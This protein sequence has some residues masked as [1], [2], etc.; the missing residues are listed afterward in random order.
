MHVD[1]ITGDE[2]FLF[3]TSCSTCY[4]KKASILPLMAGKESG[5]TK[6][7]LHVEE[8]ADLDSKIYR[9]PSATVEVPELGM[10]VEPSGAGE[11]FV[12]NVEGMLS[13][14]K[15][16]LEF[17]LKTRQAELSTVKRARETLD[18]IESC[19]TGKKSFHVILEDPEGFSY[20][21]PTRKSSL[22]KTSITTGE[23]T[24]IS[25]DEKNS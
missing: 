22:E 1:K 2:T 14:F 15:E 18:E 24:G 3:T 23:T 7:I 21:L 9:A 16:R 12:T 20:I 4:F 10:K 8:L 19:S 11:I 6:S 17:I 13:R 25:R 5:A